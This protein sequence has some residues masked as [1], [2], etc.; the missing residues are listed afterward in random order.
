MN[1]KNHVFV[2]VNRITCHNSATLKTQSAISATK[3][4]TFLK[5]V[6]HLCIARMIMRPTQ[7]PVRKQWLQAENSRDSETKLPVL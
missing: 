4:G 7:D 6:N 3:E 1:K 5:F 2:V